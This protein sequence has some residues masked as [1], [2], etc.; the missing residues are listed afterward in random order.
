MET[1]VPINRKKCDLK[2]VVRSATVE[3]YKNKKRGSVIKKHAIIML[4]NEKN[5]K[6][7]YH[8]IN[9]FII[10]TYRNKSYNSMA[11][12]SFKVVSFLNWVLFEKKNPLIDLEDLSIECATDFLFHLTEKGNQ[13]ITVKRYEDVLYHFYVYLYENNILKRIKR[14]DVLAMREKHFVKLIYNQNSVGERIHDFKT[15]L[16][17]PFIE[18]AFYEAN[19]IALGLY[20][21]IFGGLRMSEVVNVTKSNITNIGAYG[22]FG[23]V[24][25]LENTNLRPDLTTTSGTGAVKKDRRQPIF[26]YRRLLKKL[27][28]NHIKKYQNKNVDA[29]FLD[30][31][32][33]PMSGDSYRKAFKRLQRIFVNNLKKHDDIRISSYGYYLDAMKWSTHIGRGIF[34]NLMAEY[35]DN[36]LAVAVAR[37]DS[38]LNSSLTYIADTKRIMEK[39]QQELEILYK[40]DF[41]D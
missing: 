31:N 8:P 5:G 26:P 40:G 41:L 6:E 1:I 39:I 27:Y 12:A 24:L 33:N 25:K 15:E 21:Q 38:N 7:I 29:L 3:L 34:S 37:G 20:Y 16:I 14:E 22:E 35:T 13:K 28:M 23:Q 32:G 18:T 19:S 4:K 17:I 2:F 9:Q 11:G 10:E 36:V 30:R